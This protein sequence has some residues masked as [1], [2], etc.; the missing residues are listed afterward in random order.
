MNMRT[1]VRLLAAAALIA[2]AACGGRGVMPAQAP[3]SGLSFAPNAGP[4]AVD[5]CATLGKSGL[6]YFHGSCLS[7]NVK[8]SATTFKLKGYKGIA[9]TL[10]YPAASAGVPAR[11][12]FVTGEGTGKLDITGTYQKSKFPLY[13]S[14]GVPCINQSGSTEACS[15]T[16][17]L[18][19]LLVNDSAN[20]VTF[21][22]SPS[23][24]LFS[25]GLKHFR[26]CILFQLIPI[27][28]AWAW[29][30]TPVAE[31]VTRRERLMLPSYPTQGGFH[32]NARTIEVFSVICLKA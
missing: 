26:S 21:A 27:G 10:K 30:Q 9:Q 15:N 5:P 11:T 20:T 3:A 1:I 18:Y 29:Q 25:H 32:M 6:W 8:K 17:F 23:I 7:E 22:G 16:P 19:D 2:L 4:S 12:T 14:K 24:A 13:G 31:F 28:S